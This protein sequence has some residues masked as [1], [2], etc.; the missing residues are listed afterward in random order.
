[1]R[2]YQKRKTYGFQ[3][4]EQRLQKEIRGNKKRIFRSFFFLREFRFSQSPISLF[5]HTVPISKAS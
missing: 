1:M 4:A 3:S 2:I 5:S